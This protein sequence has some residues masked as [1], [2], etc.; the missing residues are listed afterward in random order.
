MTQPGRGTTLFSWLL[1]FAGG[2]A[3]FAC[4]YLPAWLE[5]RALRREH[6]AARTR[7]EQLEQRL[8]SVTKQIEH[9]RD[10][11]AYIERLARKEFGT[12]TPGVEIIPIETPEQT[13]SQPS[14]APA[15]A[16]QDGGAT[17]LER[18]ARKNPLVAVFVLNETRPIVMAMAGVLML[19]ALVMMYRGRPAQRARD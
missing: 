19:V 16:V 3:L 11:P 18:A 6:F 5:L 15:S 8:T 1:F 14:S 2:A 7:I 12:E 17:K 10:D 9:L 13:T 4:L